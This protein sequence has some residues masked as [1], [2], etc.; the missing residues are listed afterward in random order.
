MQTWLNFDPGKLF[1]LKK[2]AG[3]TLG[4]ARFSRQR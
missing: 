2:N 4:I 3:L 1:L